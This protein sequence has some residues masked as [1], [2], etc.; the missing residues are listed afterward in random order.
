MLRTRWQLNCNFVPS[1]LM[2]T[3]L[4]KSIGF[5]IIELNKHNGNIHSLY[6]YTEHSGYLALFKNTYFWKSR[7][8]KQICCKTNQSNKYLFFNEKKWISRFFILYFNFPLLCD[9]YSYSFFFSSFEILIWF[10]HIFNPTQGHI[11]SHGRNS[12]HTWHRPRTWA[13]LD[14]FR[15][16]PREKV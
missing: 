13:V 14:T 11:F 15:N 1:E 16:L 8:I 9:S 2:W 4:F 12:Y 6:R 5:N 3:S 7:S 10:Y